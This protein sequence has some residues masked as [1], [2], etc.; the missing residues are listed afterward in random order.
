[1]RKRHK[2]ICT[3]KHAHACL[4]LMHVCLYTDLNH[5]IFLV[6]YHYLMPLSLNFHKDPNF[7]CGYTWN[8]KFDNNYFE[9][10]F[11]SWNVNYKTM[12]PILFNF[13]DPASI[14]LGLQIFMNIH[15]MSI[16]VFLDFPDYPEYLLLLEKRSNSTD[17][18]SV[19]QISFFRYILSNCT[20]V[21]INAFQITFI[22]Q[23]NNWVKKNPCTKCLVHM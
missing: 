5:K 9:P 2:C 10:Y 7:C 19:C 16:N 8:V 13:K 11:C 18:F 12:N 3:T 21:L 6:V 23:F 1:M 14:A 17:W 22:C 15:Q 4:H 20:L